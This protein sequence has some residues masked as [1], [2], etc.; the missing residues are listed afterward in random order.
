MTIF[1]NFALIAILI[2]CFGLYGLAMFMAER[3]VREIGIRKVLGASERSILTLMSSDFVK[4]V[5]IAFIVAT[6]LAYWG[7]D[8]WLSTFPYRESVNIWVLVLS[9]VVALA[10][11]LMTISLQA[12]KAAKLNPVKSIG[13][14]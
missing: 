2:A 7:M 3:R 5:G 4:L 8:R 14:P 6:P 1:F 13:A 11:A 9:G 12:W 10:I